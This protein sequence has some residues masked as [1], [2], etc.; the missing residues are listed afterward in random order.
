[1][2]KQ[3]WKSRTLWFNM[4]IAAGA[5]L[6]SQMNLI[7]PYVGDAGYAALAMLVPAVNVGLRFVSTQELSA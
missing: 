4:F 6:E 2:S 5:A 1:M 3:W 7:H